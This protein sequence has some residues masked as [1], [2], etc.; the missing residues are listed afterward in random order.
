MAN[1]DKAPLAE[2]IEFVGSALQYLHH[3]DAVADHLNDVAG[4][5]RSLAETSSLTAIAQ[6]G[7]AEDRK[8]ALESLKAGSNTR[9]DS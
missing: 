8:T 9:F 7:S 2:E 3:L 6:Y 4:A 5:L 1:E